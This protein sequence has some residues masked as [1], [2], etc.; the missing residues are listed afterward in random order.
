MP[1]ASWWPCS[2]TENWE[3]STPLIMPTSRTDYGKKTIINDVIKIVTGYLSKLLATFFTQ[4]SLTKISAYP[5]ERQECD[6]FINLN[7]VTHTIRFAFYRLETTDFYS[8][9]PNLRFQ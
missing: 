1:T 8:I 9:L 6:L 3:S 4:V 5:K 7:Q 2:A